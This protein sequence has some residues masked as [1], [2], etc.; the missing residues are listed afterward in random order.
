MPQP[1]VSHPRP[2]IAFLVHSLG[3]GGAERNVANL[4]NRFAAEGWEVLVITS[5]GESADVFHL[6]PQVERQVLKCHRPSGLR[7]GLWS[8][9]CRIA[10]IRTLLKRFQPQTLV[11][12]MTTANVLGTLAAQRL[13]VRVVISERNWP[14][15]GGMRLPWRMLR[16]HVYR[17]ADHFAAQTLE[18]ADWVRSHLDLRAVTVIPNAVSVP[19]PVD[20]SRPCPEPQSDPRKLIL[21]IGTKPFQKG[22]DLLL[23]ALV[24]LLQQEPDWRLVVLGVDQKTLLTQPPEAHRP[25][26]VTALP[27]DRIR[28]LG[29]VGNP[30]AWYEA[31]DIFVLSSRF[32]GFPNVL[33]EAM[34]HGC[35]CV[36]FA[37][38]TGPAEIVEDQT[39]GL[40]VAAGDV[41]ALNLAI[42]QLMQ[43]AEA[44]KCLGQRARDVLLRY[45]EDE[46]FALWLGMVMAPS[47]GESVAAQ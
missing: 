38:P 4:A 24:P 16:K 33:V 9:V 35:A 25:Y 30:G 3:L 8:F 29:N 34:A 31:A 21:A 26:G 47:A 19:I 27:H 42:H 23:Q 5:A 17:L 15:R 20:R 7:A 44:R 22:F 18:G 1:D 28:A 41:S 36:A 6:A 40:L 2:R 10:E 37:C 14:A 11:C 46:V 43:D 32:E 12:M 45:S 39:T 13:P